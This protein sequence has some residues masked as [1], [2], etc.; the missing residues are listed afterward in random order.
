MYSLADINAYRISD[1]TLVLMDKATYDHHVAEDI[2]VMAYTAL[3]KGY[4]TKKA[5]GAS[6]PVQTTR[7]YSNPSNE[8]IFA[9]LTR[10]AHLLHCSLSELELAFLMHQELVTVP[11]VSF[12]NPEQLEQ[13][14]KSCDL[15]LDSATV[16]AF[17]QLKKYVYDAC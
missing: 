16:E 13:G 9:E 5:S 17:S 12:S 11:I 6:I 4:F 10:K 7:W 2:N 8:K 14:M 3:A 1:K 15:K